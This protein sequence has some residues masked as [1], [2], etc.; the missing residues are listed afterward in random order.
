MVTIIVTTEGVTGTE[1]GIQVAVKK[2]E[3]AE[4][5]CIATGL[6]FSDFEYQWFLNNNPVDGQENPNLVIRSVS[7]TNTGD[8]SCSV[9]NPYKGIGRSN[10]TATLILGTV[11]NYVAVII[12]VAAYILISIL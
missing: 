3:R 1:G 2:G 9:L 6:G 7:E 10:I 11:S 4:F 12:I 5:M 8:Y